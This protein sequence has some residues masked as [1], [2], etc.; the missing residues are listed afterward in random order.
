MKKLIFLLI[1]LITL[2]SFGQNNDKTKWWNKYDNLDT[3]VKKD[4]IQLITN[5]TSGSCLIKSSRNTLT[6]LFLNIAGGALISLSFTEKEDA[7]AFKIGGAV[8]MITG[9]ILQIRGIVLIGKA[10]KLMEKEKQK[11]LS[12]NISPTKIGLAFNF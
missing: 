5:E 6:G 4:S 12:Y 7:D 10:G 3:P 2:S 11:S 9:S 8:L 1:M